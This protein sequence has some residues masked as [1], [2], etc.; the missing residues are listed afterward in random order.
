LDPD[1]DTG[2]DLAS[3]KKPSSNSSTPGTSSGLASNLELSSALSSNPD[4][5]VELVAVI[6]AGP[7][8]P[9]MGFDSGALVDIS[10]G[11]LGENSVQGGDFGGSLR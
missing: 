2:L 3:D 11:D 9:V 1:L 6:T 7:L 5:V 10:F 8:I 4:A